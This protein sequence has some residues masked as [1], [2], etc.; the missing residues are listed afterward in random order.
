MRESSNFKIKIYNA[1]VATDFWDVR[2]G[3]DHIAR[4]RRVKKT[5]NYS[6]QK[7]KRNNWNSSTLKHKTLLLCFFFVHSHQLIKKANNCDDDDNDDCERV[8]T[9]LKNYFRKHNAIEWNLSCTFC[10]KKFFDINIPRN[11]CSLLL[12]PL[13][14]A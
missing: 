10:M 1:K 4:D 8:A 2:D 6:T 3:R 5:W 14:M 13:S 7:N 12:L 9:I 11:W